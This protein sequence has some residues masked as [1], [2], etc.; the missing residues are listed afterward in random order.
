MFLNEKGQGTI[1]ILRI[2]VFLIGVFFLIQGLNELGALTNL[3]DISSLD[4]GADK[5]DVWFRPHCAGNKSRIS[6]SNLSIKNSTMREKMSDW[7]SIPMVD[8]YA[9]LE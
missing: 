2:V 9:I 8:E 7:N 4:N 5:S 3:N 1:V 6:I